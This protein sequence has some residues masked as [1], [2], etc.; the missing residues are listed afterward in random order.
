MISRTQRILLLLANACS[1]LTSQKIAESI[2]VSRR[3]IINDIP[4]VKDALSQNGAEFKEEYWILYKC[5]EQKH[6]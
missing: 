2:G 5:H 6:F 3:T 1:P 4:H